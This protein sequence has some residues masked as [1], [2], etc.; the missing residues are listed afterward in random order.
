MTGYNHKDLQSI[1]ITQTMPK[2]FKSLLPHLGVNGNVNGLYKSFQEVSI[3]R[4]SAG[5]R[6]ENRRIDVVSFL[7]VGQP[8]TYPKFYERQNLSVC[9]EVKA[10]RGSIES[11]NKYCLYKK[12]SDLFFFAVPYYLVRDALNRASGQDDVGVVEIF[13][14]RIV[15]M[16]RF[17]AVVPIYYYQ[18]MQQIIY[19]IPRSKTLGK[20]FVLPNE[21]LIREYLE[22]YLNPTSSLPSGP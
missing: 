1:L 7:S 22:D 11:D 14:G 10:S 15:K 20:Q 8:V 16:P 13:T 12:C 17:Q 18:L 19:C 4:L 5:G 9:F 6:K 3:E 2:F 21:D